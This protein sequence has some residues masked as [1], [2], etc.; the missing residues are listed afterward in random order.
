MLRYYRFIL[1]RS[2]NLM[3]LDNYCVNR[4][5]I[6]SFRSASSN[7]SVKHDPKRRQPLSSQN[8]SEKPNV[9]EESESEKLTNSLTN[10]GDFYGVKTRGLAPAPVSTEIAVSKLQT[11]L[12]FNQRITAESFVKAVLIPLQEK[13]PEILKMIKL[14]PSL[15]IPFFIRCCGL[16]MS[17]I[18]HDQ[19]L[20]I[21]EHLL[22]AFKHNNIK[23][24][25]HAY[26]ALLKVWMENEHEYDVNA[27]LEEVEIDLK[28]E[29]NV[30]FYN[31]LLW[32]LAETKDVKQMD[33]LLSR[34]TSQG[35]LPNLQTELSQIFAASATNSDEKAELLVNKVL[36]KY[37][38]DKLP[39]CLSAKIRG[40]LLHTKLD[41]F[42]KQLR[43]AVD[44]AK[45]GEDIDD[46]LF[47]LSDLS[48]Q[49]PYVF[50][51]QNLLFELIKK[52]AEISKPEKPAKNQLYG[53]KKVVEVVSQI[54]DLFPP[55]VRHFHHSKLFALFETL[56]NNSVTDFQSASRVCNELINID[57]MGDRRVFLE[58]AAKF[59][60]TK[61]KYD[62]AFYYWSS[63]C[64][65]DNIVSGGNIFLEHVLSNNRISMKM[66]E[67]RISQLVK[68]YE[69]VLSP[70]DVIAQL[71]VS[72][73]ST[74]RMPDAKVLWIK[75]AV[76]LKHFLSPI[77][78][79]KNVEL[80]DVNLIHIRDF[81]QLLEDC[82]LAEFK[83]KKR[84]RKTEA[85]VDFETI[86]S[87]DVTTAQPSSFKPGTEREIIPDGNM[88]FLIKHW[89]PFR[90]RKYGK[91]KIKKFD[92]RADQLESLINLVQEVWVSL[93][94]LKNDPK[95]AGPEE[96]EV[97]LARNKIPLNENLQKRVEALQK[98]AKIREL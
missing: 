11:S 42:R 75:T 26:V 14:D 40:T 10:R 2:K 43:L 33:K 93:I 88:E 80:V 29:T 74:G 5:N 92:I 63:A 46:I 70:S 47:I 81:A 71:I 60:I 84:P 18:S 78:K 69:R 82:V 1:L 41:K 36:Q 87:D 66:Q 32:R 30:E 72:L 8:R 6:Q 17:D 50:L 65:I 37:G 21:L 73:V 45:T 62:D 44:S 59:L 52:A 19:K 76:D 4:L 31:K 51:N 23:M 28:M 57:L 83:A 22:Q 94:E 48:K 49:K 24:D 97:F 98:K 38:E 12:G 96:F 67:R 9:V 56:F 85:S 89:Q 34:M 58:V 25:I 77:R 7:T 91:Q 68:F 64:S 15:Y 95:I 39:R 61:L 20:V 54:K 90:K 55:G 79:L 86:S 3:P 13:N 16:V 27:I 53:P 35:I